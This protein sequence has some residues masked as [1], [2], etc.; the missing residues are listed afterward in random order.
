MW[1][2]RT[3][4]ILSIDGGG[5]R[6]LIP[7]MVLQDLSARMHAL[8]R[9]RPL[10]EC[11]DMIS[12]TSTGALIALGLTLPKRDS[13]QPAL[14]IDEIVHKYRTEGTRIFP[15]WKFEYLHDVAHAFREKYSIDNF[16]HFLGPLFADMTL[17]DCLSDVLIPSYDVEGNTPFFFKKRSTRGDDMNFLMKDVAKA[18]SAAPSYFQPAVIAEYGRPDNDYCM[19]DGAVFANNPAMCAYIEARKLYPRGRRFE[20]LS[21]G[22]GSAS[23]ELNRE[24]LSTWGFFE[25]LSP[26]RGSPLFGIMSSG[27]AESV[28][29]QLTKLRGVTYDRIN[30]SFLGERPDMDDAS[31]ENIRFLS[32]AAGRIIREHEETLEALARRL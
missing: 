11:F 20:I 18:A 15:P 5:I 30:G 3:I 10:H 17:Q 2:F 1:P 7:A 8:G 26:L 6:G 4:R 19:V 21:L 29:Y 31:P 27:Q 24:D 9:G 23:L 22:T 12:G 16:D 13:R 25:W 28:D 32:D 14:S